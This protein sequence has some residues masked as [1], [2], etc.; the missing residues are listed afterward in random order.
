M[1]VEDKSVNPYN[2]VKKAG[3]SNQPKDTVVTKDDTG[4]TEGTLIAR[5]FITTG[6]ISEN[7]GPVFMHILAKVYH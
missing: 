4:S 5:I 2:Y 6:P 3:S 1:A 7:N